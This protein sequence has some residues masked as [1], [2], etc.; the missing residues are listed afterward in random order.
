MKK[1]VFL[2]GTRA[3]YGKLKSV[4][5]ELN[6]DK[7]FKIYIYVTGMHLLEKYGSTY[8]EIEKDGFDEIF[9]STSVPQDLTLDEVLA[10]NILQFT[11]Y[12]KE[13]KPDMII[14]HGDRVEALA[15]AI[16]GAFNNIY[17]GHIEGGEISGTIDESIRHAIS[18][19]AN[20]HFVSNQSSKKNLIQM[21]EAK[22]HI[23]VVGSP[24]IDIM[25]RNNYDI[26][27]V[28][29]QYDIPFDNY[30][31][32]IY[33]PVLSEVNQL[34]KNVK[35][36]VDAIIASKQN[37]IIIYPNNDVGTDIILEEYKRFND[38]PRI[39]MYPSIR[40]EYFLTL[41]KNCS[42]V[43]GNSSLGIR[44][45]GIYGIPAI[46]IGT[47]QSGRYDLSVQKNVC[48]VKE[49]KKE[50]LNAIK[51]VDGHRYKSK[52]FGDG[53]SDKKI[54]KILKDKNLWKTNIQ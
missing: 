19:L 21:G 6:K 10:E 11:K 48:C 31:I 32:F 22:E 54:H 36:V 34:Q 2:T 16:V 45:T 37:Y 9:L 23:F 51:E 20:F 4:I 52:V 26:K 14:V 1:I 39:K 17:V 50:I 5:K 24:D 35:K 33:H 53:K 7:N 28:K 38:N 46:N 27:E 8:R 15:G 42:F 44:E 29:K 30:G 3:D 41:L 40:F 49:N 47:R 13:I 18:K 12:I 25:L 43:I